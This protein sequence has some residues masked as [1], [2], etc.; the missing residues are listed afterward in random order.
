MLGF[1]RPAV[2][3]MAIPGA[4]CELPGDFRAEFNRQR[5]EAFRVMVIAYLREELPKAEEQSR[6]TLDRVIAARQMLERE[7]LVRDR[8]V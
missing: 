8:R 2:T 3:L 4:L 6:E 5:E 7:D 1:D